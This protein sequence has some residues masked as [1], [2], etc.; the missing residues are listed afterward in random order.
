MSHCKDAR[1]LHQEDEGFGIVG[2]PLDHDSFHNDLWRQ[3]MSL[4]EEGGGG[5]D[6]G[7]EGEDG[8]AALKE[9]VN[10]KLLNFVSG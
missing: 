7:E 1:R 5:G 10:D 8:G 2:G 9:Y 4:R 3:S 6:G